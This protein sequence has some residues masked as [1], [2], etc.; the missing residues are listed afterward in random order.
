MQDVMLAKKDRFMH[1]KLMGANL[2][3]HPKARLLQVSTLHSPLLSCVSA[4]ARMFASFYLVTAMGF[5]Q[6]SILWG[7]LGQEFW[8]SKQQTKKFGPN[9]SPCVKK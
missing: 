1:L 7:I 5:M 6:K 9:P 2:D 4:S 3:S 8:P